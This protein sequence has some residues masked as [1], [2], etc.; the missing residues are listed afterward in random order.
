MIIQ[1]FSRALAQLPD[2]KFRSVL[3]RGLLLTAALYI[4][5][6]FV[7]DY[8]IAQIGD[9]W[10]D[11][12]DDLLKAAG[13]VAAIIAAFVLFP[14]LASFFMAFFLD[15]IA[16]AV[17]KLHYPSDPPGKSAPLATSLG[18]SLRFTVAL[19][20]LNILALPF[21]L[22]PGIN[23]FLYYLLNGYLLSREYFELAGQRHLAPAGIRKARRG[24]GGKLMLAGIAI[25]FL[26]TIPLVNFVAPLLATAVMV[27]MHKSMSRTGED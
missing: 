18:I 6:F 20:V 25:A 1:A 13:W 27:H 23:L 14:A 19:I 3:I 5:L 22:I 26:L 4:G 7:A 15:E 8:F 21:Y 9:T 24:Q 16:E 2:P 11:W 10:F 12:L 17:E